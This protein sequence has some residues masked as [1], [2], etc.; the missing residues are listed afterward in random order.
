MNN[1]DNLIKANLNS[2]EGHLFI[3][4]LIQLFYQKISKLDS[5]NEANV[6]LYCLGD[7]QNILSGAVFREEVNIKVS[8][9]LWTFIKEYERV[10]DIW[11]RE[12]LFNKIKAET[13]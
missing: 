11:Q 9:F 8:D 7:I 3:E 13:V 10:D 4:N 12:F 1:F 5:F 6:F 2:V